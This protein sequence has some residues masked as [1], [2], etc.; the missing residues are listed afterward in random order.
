MY[1]LQCCG[2]QFYKQA[3]PVW[4]VLYNKFLVI[5]NLYAKQIVIVITDFL[6]D[7]L[8]SKNNKH[9]SQSTMQKK[10]MFF[11][12]DRHQIFLHLLCMSTLYIKA[13]NTN[14]QIQDSQ[15]RK[16]KKKSTEYSFMKRG[17]NKT[18]QIL[19]NVLQKLC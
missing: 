16:K 14:E 15:K 7:F 4:K 19:F 13:C 12:L 3:N 11:F 5:V 10:S 6:I 1:Y 8:T 2:N 9:F 17:S 18:L